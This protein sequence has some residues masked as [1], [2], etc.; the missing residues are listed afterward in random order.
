MKT[1]RFLYLISFL[2]FYFPLTAQDTI[3]GIVNQYAKVIGA[4]QCE[5]LLILERNE[6]F[7]PG[8][9][10]VIYQAKGATMLTQDNSG[11]GTILSLGGAGLYE[12]NTVL[13]VQGD[14]IVLASTMLH[15]YEP[16][17]AVQ[18]VK[19]PVFED[20]VIGDT[21]KPTAWNG[22]IGGILAIRVQGELELN[23]PISAN[24][25]GFRGGEAGISQENDC[26][27]WKFRTEYGLPADNWR[28]ARKGEGIAAYVEGVE[29]G[30][31]AQANGGGG[32]ND[33][34]SGGG[35]G[36][37][38]GVGGIGGSNNEPSN[39]GCAGRWPGFGGNSIDPGFRAIGSSGQ[40]FSGPDRLFFGGGGGAG[41]DNNMNS[42][43]GGNGGGIILIRADRIKGN[44]YI[45]SAN[46]AT[47]PPN[48]GDGAGGGGAGG[49]ILLYQSSPDNIE[50][51]FS[52]MVCEVNGGDGG[53]VDNGAQNRCMGPGGGGGA[54]IIAFQ[55]GGGNVSGSALGGAPG[56]SSN[57]IACSNGNNGAE[58]GANGQLFPLGGGLIALSERPDLI[59]N[60]PVQV[61]GCEKDSA[62]LMIDITGIFNSLQW[63]VDKGNGRELLTDDENFRGTQTNELFIEAL[64][65][66]SDGWRFILEANGDCDIIVDHEIIVGAVPPVG[67]PVFNF[68]NESGRTVLFEP[69]SVSAEDSVLWEFGDGETSQSYNPTHTYQSDGTF[70]IRLTVFNDCGSNFSVQEISIGSAPEAMFNIKGVTE[71]CA[72]ISIQ[73]LGSDDNLN[74][75][76]TFEG[77]APATST[78]HSPA[79]WYYNPGSYDVQLVVSN[80]FGADTL[81]RE[82]YIVLKPLPE[83]D[84]SFNITDQEV[85]FINESLSATAYNWRFGDGATS[86]D[87]HP[88]HTY[89]SPG[90]YEV[91][92]N[93]SNDFCV[94][95]ISKSVVIES[96]AME[97]FSEDID[98][99]VFPNPVHNILHIQLDKV[100]MINRIYIL[101]VVGRPFLLDKN[102]G[103]VNEYS[104]DQYAAG[105]Y[106][107]V[108]Q[109]TRGVLRIPI[110]IVR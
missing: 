26:A 32:G 69:Q 5:K 97:V 19:V 35:G 48:N 34:N 94:T 33:H 66:E 62:S 51:E 107:L 30:R 65:V 108:F 14:S 60:G 75:Q 84:F 37:N 9:E 89:A 20:V 103:M 105:H 28:G 64:P 61:L 15:D 13:T 24:G 106:Q 10:V 27:F 40:L 88:V 98:L 81:L 100:E 76:W 55:F 18:L 78:A 80:G 73:F 50:R 77:G 86:M 67:T 91:T 7:L 68:T 36:A 1:M 21:L 90:T 56:V 74:Y 43:N 41:H 11:F 42:T 3:G 23:A 53:T 71:G 110:Q 99:S 25:L 49:S 63:Y 93:A 38:F 31:G 54:G 6:D 87:E 83:P 2:V 4:E 45:I 46:G 92:L 16:D 72:P 57:S 47:P 96:T 12:W 102:P 101:D 29:A 70:E 39:F 58:S 82:D 109:T 17:G 104:L 85:K 59:L 22:E 8:D 95:A 52:D 44:N 79:I